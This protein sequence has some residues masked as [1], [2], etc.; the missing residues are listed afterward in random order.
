MA[1]KN[2]A[3][4]DRFVKSTLDSIRKGTEDSGMVLNGN[5]Q[6]ELAVVKLKEGE[7]GVKVYVVDAGVKYRKE[8]IS[9]ITF[10]IGPEP[11]INAKFAAVTSS[12][13]FLDAV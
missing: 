9:K 4:L 3:E 10:E 11:P 2:I 8:E 1:E 6:F 7:G 12:H 13:G 5:I